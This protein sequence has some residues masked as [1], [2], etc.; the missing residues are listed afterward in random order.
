M[1]VE[2]SEKDLETWAEYLLSYSLGG[3]EPDD[4]VMLKG[5]PVTW[6]LLSKLQDKVFAAGAIADLNLVAP[7]NDRGKV[8]GAS[9]ARHGS[10]E[11][12]A[13]VPGWHRERYESMTKY[14]EVMGSERPELF[15]GLPDDTAMALAKADEEFRRTRGLKRWVLTLFPTQ[16]FADIEEM[17]L[18]DYARVVV[19]AS[20]QDPRKLETIEEPIR[21]LMDRSKRLRFVTRCPKHDRDLELS[22]DISPGKAIPC[23]GIRNFPDGEVFTSP[24]SRHTEGEIFVDMPVF[25]GGAVIEG[26][27]LKFEGGNI[28]DYRANKGGDALAKIIETDAGSKRLGEVALG[29]NAGIEAVLRHPLF[30]EKVGGTVHIAIGASYPICFTDDPASEAGQARVAALAEEGVFNKSA[31]HVDIVTDFRGNGAGKAVFFDD[32]EVVVRDGI[33]VLP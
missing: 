23:T 17:S 18:A 20:T 13:R 24:D 33:W 15:D 11:Q 6:P 9:I 29:M 3:I 28:V 31:Q 14:V 8:F 22:I 16:G 26:V 32:T 12:I 25:Q 30:V 4:V 5:E 10:V 21:Q 2:I 7:D 19:A 1:S 27:Y